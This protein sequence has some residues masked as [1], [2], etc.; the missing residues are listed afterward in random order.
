[1]YTYNNLPICGVIF[2]MKIDDT[3]LPVKLFAYIY[4]IGLSLFCVAI[5]LTAKINIYNENYF[6]FFC[7]FC[8]LYAFIHLL[9]GICVVFKFNIGYK[10]LKFYLLYFLRLGY[11]IGTIIANNMLKYMDENNIEK[12][13]RGNGRPPAR[14]LPPR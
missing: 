5:P 7:Y 14:N 11:P 9:I 3:F 4:F 2:N 8:Y 1:M 13:F 12:Y 10:C 6:Y